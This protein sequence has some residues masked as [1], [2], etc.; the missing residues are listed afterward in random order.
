MISINIMQYISISI[1]DCL[2][3]KF[4]FKS[5]FQNSISLKLTYKN[6]HKSKISFE[7]LF[8]S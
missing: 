4:E 6:H 7:K 3:L 1:Y 2:Q 5:H 8:G